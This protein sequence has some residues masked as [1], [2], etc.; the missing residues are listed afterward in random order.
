MISRKGHVTLRE[1]HMISREGHVP[2]HSRAHTSIF[3]LQVYYRPSD[4][5]EGSPMTETVPASSVS[6]PAPYMLVGLSANTEYTIQVSATTGGGTGDRST[7]AVVGHTLA[8][9]T[10]FLSSD[11]G[12]S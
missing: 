2:L 11:S 3:I 7:P 12:I 4:P 10:G 5:R 9:G 1:S 8:G 6:P